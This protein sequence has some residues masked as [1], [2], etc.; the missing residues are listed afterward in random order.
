M[1]KSVAWEAVIGHHKTL[2]STGLTDQEKEQL[3]R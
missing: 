1:R 2:F 3:T